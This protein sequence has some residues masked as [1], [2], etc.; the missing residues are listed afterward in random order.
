V[1]RLSLLLIAILTLVVLGI[2]SGIVT[3]GLEDV[4]RARREQ[5]ILEERKIELEQEIERLQQ[6][7][8]SLRTDPDAVESL[9]RRD[10]GWIRPGEQVIL[11]ATPTPPPTPRPLTGPTP[12]PILRLRK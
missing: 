7:L 1:K 11:L 4:A 2:L 6:T 8:D 10:L 12:T 9:A 3:Q 5:R